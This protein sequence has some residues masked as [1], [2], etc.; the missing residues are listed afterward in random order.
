M[1]A[2]VIKSRSGWKTHSPIPIWLWSISFYIYKQNE[3]TYSSLNPYFYNDINLMLLE[4]E[5]WVVYSKESLEQS[6]LVA[7]FSISFH[8][9]GNPAMHIR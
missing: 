2:S 5:L 9:H 8:C 1:D 7:P 4:H 3:P 6:C